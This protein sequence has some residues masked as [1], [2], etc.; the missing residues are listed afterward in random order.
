MESQILVAEM[1]SLS[2]SAG[3]INKN[4]VYYIPQNIKPLDNWII[5]S[6]NELL[7]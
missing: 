4:T 5:L 7:K 3:I 1:S 2:L 6:E